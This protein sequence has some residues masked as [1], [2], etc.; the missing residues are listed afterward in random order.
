[1]S[2]PANPTDQQQM[3][4]KMLTGEIV[5]STDDR[6]KLVLANL[7]DQRD[8]NVRILYLLEGNGQPGLIARVGA[9][10]AAGDAWRWV[11]VQLTKAL[12]AI[13]A[14]VL[15]GVGAWLVALASG[16]VTWHP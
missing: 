1:V 3:L 6:W 2:I 10:E 16:H 15:L 11:R 8:Q 5:L 4:D 13:I 12:P 14:T 9:L 7:R